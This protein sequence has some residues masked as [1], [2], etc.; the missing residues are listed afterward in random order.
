MGLRR[1]SIRLRIVLLVAIPILSLIG[2]Y[3]FAATIT[4]TDAINLA[5]SRTLKDTVGTPTG[6]LEA[7]IDVERLLAVAYLAAPVPSNLAALRAQEAKTEVTQAAFAK[8][9]AATMGDDSP[10]EKQAIAGLLRAVSGLRKLRSEIASR[11]IGR[12]Q[13]VSGYAGII[14]DSDSVLNQAILQEN[15]VELATQS[16]ALVRLGRSEEL[17]LEE[18]VL[19]NGDAIA[20][21]FSAADRQQ[22]TE[23]A[24][25]RRAIYAQTLPDLEPLYRAYYLRDVSPQAA[26]AL[27]ALENKVIADSR[28]GRVPPVALPDWNLTVGAVSAG[29]SNASVQAATELTVRAQPVADATFLR[30]YLVGGLGLLAV[31]VSIGM[32]LWIGRGLVQQLA[33]LRRSAHD[34]ARERLPSVVARLRAGQEV[35]VAAEVPPLE[36][37]PDEIGQVREAFNRAARTAVAAAVDEA[38]LRRGVSDVFRNLARRSQSLLHRQLALLDAMERRAG[39]PEELEDLFR[40]DHLTTRMRR[41]SESLII[42]SGAPPARGWRHPVPFIDVLRAAVA[43]VEDYA[44]IRVT[45]GSSAALTGPAVADVIHLL[46]ELAENATVYSPPSAP[47]RVHGDVVGRGF[48]IEVEDR[49]LGISQERLA[50]INSNLAHP[51][52]FDLSGSEQLGLFV[53]GQLAKRHDIR[54]TLQASPFGGTTAI[55]LI[56]TSLVVDEGSDAAALPALVPGEGQLRLPSRPATLVP[57]VTAGRA[58]LPGPSDLPPDA[59]GERTEAAA[60]EESVFTPRRRQPAG[61]AFAFLSDEPPPRAFLSDQPPPRETSGAGLGVATA[62]IAGLGL[63]GRVPQAGLAPQ[64]RDSGPRDDD[65]RAASSPSPEAA[66]SIMTALQRGWERGRYVSGSVTPPPDTAFDARHENGGEQLSDQ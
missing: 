17:L 34:L 38:R 48:A 49:G 6:N 56:P 5:R 60:E 51:P 58:A 62:E 16:L 64:L 7:Q 22:F 23:L 40:I 55:V 42:L 27:E 39:G 57:G 65:D 2:V 20:R 41:N 33:A 47:V 11:A 44:R 9:A 24:G 59:P 30:L 46:A 52:E 45:V 53:A 61:N 26:A 3:A 13:A 50:E 37:S 4:A 21:T 19:I 10:G 31:L 28:P 8:A 25:A 36:T 18:D 15:N 14:A 54:I 66:R 35:D 12:P 43:E 1:R 32:S 63:P 29:I